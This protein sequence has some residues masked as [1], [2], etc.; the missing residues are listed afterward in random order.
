MTNDSVSPE[1][2]DLGLATDITRR[3]FLNATMLGVGAAL[4]HQPAPAEQPRPAANQAWT[5]YPGIGDYARSNGNTWEVVTAAHDLRDGKYTARLASARDTGEIYDLVVVGGGFSG[6]GAAYHFHKLRGATTGTVL[7][8]DNHRMW[9]GEAKRNEVVV[10]GVRLIGPQ[11][12]NGFGARIRNDWAGDYWRELG[13]PANPAQFRHQVWSERVKPLEMAREH[14]FFQLWTDEFASHG[15]F[16]ADGK[17]G[18]RLVRDAFRSGLVETPWSDQLRTDFL[19]W[20]SDPKRYYEGADWERW[21]DTMTYDDYITKVMGLDPAVA[22]YVDPIMAG[23]IGLGSDVLSA[24]AAAQ[25]S[26]P[27]FAG[28]GRSYPSRELA[29]MLDVVDSFPGGNDGIARHV[30][31]RLVPNAIAGGPGLAGVLDGAIRFDALDRPHQPTRIRLGATVIRVE[32][33]GSGR[34]GSVAVTYVRDGTLHR[35]RAHGV[36]MA[37]GGWSSQ[38]V[39]TDLPDRYRDAFRSLVRAPMLVANVALRRWRFMYDQGITAASYRDKFGFCCSLRQSI[40]TDSY[41][42]PIDP[43]RPNVLTFYVP[44]SK[45]GSA[46]RDQAVAGRNALLA[47]SYREYERQIREQLVRLFGSSGFD[48]ARDIGA[49]VLN[50]WGHAYVCPG[51]GFYF[52]RD[53]RPAPPDVIRQPLGR[54][55]F[56]NGELHGHQNWRDA[57]AEGRRAV[58]QLLTGV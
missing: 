30:V 8:L 52:G 47:T 58:E 35:V 16:F 10:D 29:K 55:A 27:G 12:S 39:V 44:F 24:N 19:R 6:L 43:D 49:I 48:P 14:Y 33:R 21:L 51:P 56:A 42:P 36:V 32:Q 13:L 45:P 41:R 15:H 31:K 18:L 4:L 23:G 1:E 3:D 57:T 34:D 7:V 2:R 28:F 38:H 9:G 46:L 54:V 25:I 40:I 11:G 37:N 50:R 20:R 5:G 26:L 53:G 22:R 17:G